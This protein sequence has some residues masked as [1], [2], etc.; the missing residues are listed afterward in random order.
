M[1]RQVVP[2]DIIDAPFD[3]GDMEPAIADDLR[4][5]ADRIHTSISKTVDTIVA[6]GNELLAAKEHLVKHGQFRIWVEDAVGIQA[7]TAQNYMN[8]ARLA[9]KR[10]NETI[11]HLRPA[12]LYQLAAPSTPPQ[13]VDAVLSRIEGG[14]PMS[15][16]VVA[17]IVGDARR[18]QRRID[19]DAAAGLR[20]TKAHKEAKR[21][22]QAKWRE[23]LA[24]REVAYLAAAKTI[25]ER[26]GTETCIWLQEVL[27]I[28]YWSVLRALDQLIGEKA[29]S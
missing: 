23:E 12:A 3:Y 1:K 4:A 11:S 2:I 29:A 27:S 17:A 19:R 25:H 15:D 5:R 28:D 20:R 21:A 18:Q 10:K 14:K 26:L 7:R 24:A 9:G 8:A 6:I 13:A 16:G 22:E